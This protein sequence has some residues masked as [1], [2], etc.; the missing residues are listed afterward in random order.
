MVGEDLLAK[1]EQ[2][3]ET[4][5]GATEREFGS[6]RTGRASVTLLDRIYVDSYGQRMPLKQVATVSVPD[7]RTVLVQPWDKSI[8]KDVERAI[9]QSGLGLTPTNDGNLIRINI[10]PLTEERREEIVKLVKKLAE[11]GRVA[12]RRVRGDTNK[13]IKANQKAGAISEDD[14]QRLMEKVQELT[15]DY[16][17]RVDTLLA[18]KEEEIMEI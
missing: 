18:A 2:K 11:E 15:D 5:L 3:M 9:Y 13:E 7:A 12:V 16:V 8:I 14:A 10:P 4:T 6:I 1:A 17:E